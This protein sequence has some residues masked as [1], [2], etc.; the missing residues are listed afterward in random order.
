M[1]SISRSLKCKAAAAVLIVALGV[2]P[3][4]ATVL[5]IPFFSQL[6]PRWANATICCTVSMAMALAYR[7]ANV[8]P[9]KLI[10][11]LWWNKGYT[12]NVVFP[13]NFKVAVNYQGKHWLDYDGQSTLG[14][15][16]FQNPVTSNPNQTSVSWA[17][18]TKRSPDSVA[19]SVARHA[20]ASAVIHQGR[21]AVMPSMMPSPG[22][23]GPGR[24]L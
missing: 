2:Q 20:T 22:G 16:F 8:D 12:G 4:A 19:T 21:G 1:N 18:W 23:R 14:F 13:V 3:A 15:W 9:P 11:W 17:A 5:S 6:D 7:G 24:R 10:N